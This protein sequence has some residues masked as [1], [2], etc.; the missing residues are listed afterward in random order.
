MLR[1]AILCLLLLG[2]CGAVDAVKNARTP[3]EAI[4]L[5]R[6]SEGDEHA[7]PYENDPKYTAVYCTVGGVQYRATVA[8]CTEDGGEATPI[9]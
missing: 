6:K 1:A 5:L 4:Y 2:G 3:D 8:S 9:R 7:N